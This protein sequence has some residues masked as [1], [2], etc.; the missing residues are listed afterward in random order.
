LL[1]LGC[2]ALERLVFS[3]AFGASEA[4]GSPINHSVKSVQNWLIK[5][6]LVLL[7]IDDCGL[8]AVLD[9]ILSHQKS[10]DA[11]GIV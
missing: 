4:I 11:L 5:S 1:R 8:L 3:I 7:Y 2:C 6:L 10:I 9:F